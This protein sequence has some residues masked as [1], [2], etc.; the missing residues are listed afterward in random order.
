MVAP[1][2]HRLPEVALDV[3]VTVPPEQKVVGPSVVMVGVGGKGNIVTLI[4]ADASE[5]QPLLV[6][7]TT[8]VLVIFTGVFAAL[9]I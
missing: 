1:L 8:K 7:V 5:V 3:K 6:V 2:L 9:T 4:G